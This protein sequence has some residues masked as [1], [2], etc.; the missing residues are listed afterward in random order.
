MELILTFLSFA[1]RHYEM[2]DS[3]YI[4]LFTADNSRWND[5]VADGQSLEETS[6]YG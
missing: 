6:L 3:E 1:F 2:M 5:F 4:S